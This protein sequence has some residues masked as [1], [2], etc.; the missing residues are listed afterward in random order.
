MWQLPTGYGRIFWSAEQ[1]LV[2]EQIGNKKTFPIQRVIDSSLWSEEIQKMNLSEWIRFLYGITLGTS[3]PLIDVTARPH[4]PLQKKQ[5]GNGITALIGGVTNC[6]AIE[7]GSETLLINTNMAATAEQIMHEVPG[8]VTH[9]INQKAHRYFVGGNEF[10]PEARDIYVG[11]Y[12][13]PVLIQHFGDRKVPNHIVSARTDLNWGGHQ[14]IIEAI[15]TGQFAK[16][17]VIFLPEIKTLL[18]G[19]LFYHK[20]FPIFKIY[21][22]VEIKEWISTL[23][24]LLSQYQPDQ[25]IPAE[26]E[27]ATA[28]GVAE[29]TKFL[30][31]VSV[32]GA[33]QSTLA[34]KYPWEEIQGLS[35]LNDCLEYFKK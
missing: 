26:G 14:I 3:T 23:E 10:Y 8:R 9:I 4:R 33:L 11:S 24:K 32:P 18:L 15:S 7:K 6:V 12:P 35:S 28:A 5:L 22:H 20:I 13:R 29:F 31:E 34:Q 21:D 2:S 19:D 25:I 1:Y 17:L 27:I 30:A 16:N